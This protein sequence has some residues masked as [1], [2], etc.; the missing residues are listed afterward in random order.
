MNYFASCL[1]GDAKKYKSLK[2]S[3]NLKEG[4]TLWLLGD[5]IDG[6]NPEES[7]EILSDAM[8]DKQIK[9]ILGDHE[10][11]HIM[12][13]LSIENESVVAQWEDFLT[14]L[15]PSGKPLVDYLKECNI[16]D[17]MA[18]INYLQD[19]EVS[20][21]VKIGSSYFYLI[22][23]YPTLYRGDDDVMNW[24]MK[25]VANGP[26]MDFFPY[27][28]FQTD[29]RFKPALMDVKNPATQTNSFLIMGQTSPEQAANELGLPIPEDGI[30]YKNRM[31]AI[32]R[33]AITDPIP[34]MGIDAAG[35]FTKAII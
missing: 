26:G 14:S 15:Y 19:C 23:G 34:L 3:A 33:S 17:A 31:F 28:F 18:Y 4:D 21:Y 5:V 16:D 25:C 30:F 13:N 20:E 6:E 1:Y 35:F 12:R 9:I 32:G 29:P 2:Q 8:N 22:H 24:Q 7:I 27:R 10:Y 11:A